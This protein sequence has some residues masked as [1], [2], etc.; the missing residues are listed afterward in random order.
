MS[1][2]TNILKER[3]DAIAK[4]IEQ[5][6]L[7]GNLARCPHCDE[8]IDL[9][10][11]C[12]DYSEEFPD[13]CPHCGGDLTDE[14]PEPY[15][16]FDWLEG[17]LSWDYIIGS[18]GAYKGAEVLIAW[19]GPSIILDTRNNEIRGYW[20]TDRYSVCGVTCASID[21]ALEEIY[22]CR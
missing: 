15:G 2:T 19:G 18:N 1:S 4:S 6:E 5:I 20:W 22:N 11:G 9:C 10:D 13:A 12:E 21:E 17:V 7:G 3:C 14:T 8:I 16:A